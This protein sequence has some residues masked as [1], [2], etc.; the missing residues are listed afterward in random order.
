MKKKEEKRR[1]NR[2]EGGER[3]LGWIFLK[4]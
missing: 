3:L 2:V 4:D 1:R